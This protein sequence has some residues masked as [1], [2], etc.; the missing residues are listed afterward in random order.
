MN[1]NFIQKEIK[2]NLKSGNAFYNSVQN[3]SYSSLLTKNLKIK[4]Y[5]NMFPVV[6]Y[7]CETWSLTLRQEQR[8]RSFENRVLR[9]L[10]LRGTR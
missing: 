8:L 9:K 4:I 7:V 6:W 3:P 5:R 1:Q 10:S 2:R